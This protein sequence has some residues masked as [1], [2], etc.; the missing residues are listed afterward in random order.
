MI[1]SVIFISITILYLLV[2]GRFIYGFDKVPAF[3]LEDMPAKTKFSVIVPFRNEATDLPKLLASISQ[4]NY[5]SHLTEFIFIDDDSSDASVSIIQ[6]YAKTHKLPITILKN[7]RSSNSPKKDA[8]TTA[9]N[10]VKT[11]WII[12]TDAD[13]ELP[14]YWLDTYDCFIQNNPQ[15]Q[16][17]VA[18]VS[19]NSSSRILDRFQTLDFFSLIGTTI[20]AFGIKKPFLC[21]GANLGYTK[22]LF[23][24][25]NGFDNNNNIASGDDVFLLQKAIKKDPKTV[26]Y[27]KSDRVVVKTTPEKNLKNLISQRIRWA[28]KTTSYSSMYATFIGVAV[29]LMNMLL[30]ASIV[31]G[32]TGVLKPQFIGYIFIIKSGIDF[33]LLFKTARFL[34]QEQLLSSYLFSTVFYPFFCVYIAVLSTFRGYKWKDRSFNK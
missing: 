32:I 5:A 29:L 31:L 14:K 30:L 19:Y 23:N 21:N 6:K 2:I 25:V 9:I 8:I 10:H 27:L 17:I 7:K 11:E 16:M 22:T 18:P 1:L 34:N 26:S 3:N 28:S 12:T 20:G 24:G 33:L 13:C 4:L 15:K